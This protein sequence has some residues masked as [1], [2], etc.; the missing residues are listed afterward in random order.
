MKA[1]RNR[2]ATNRRKAAGGNRSGAP[3]RMRPGSFF[4]GPGGFYRRAT[5]SKKAKQMGPL[6]K[7]IKKQDPTAWEES[8]SG[9]P[10]SVWIDLRFNR[11][12]SLLY[13]LLRRFSSAHYLSEI[14]QI[15]QAVNDL[16][17]RLICFDLDYP[18]LMR[19]RAIQQ[20]KS[21]HPEIPILMLTEYHSEAV[22]VWALRTRVWDYLVKPLPA[23]EFSNRISNIIRLISNREESEKPINSMP[24]PPIPAEVRF[25]VARSK[26]KKTAP[27]LSCIET[28]YPEK[29]TLGRV[30]GLCGMGPF[31]FSRMFKRENGMTFQEFLIQYRI[32]KA[33]ELFRNPHISV[34]EVAFA[35]GFNDLSY[36][37]RV[38]R[39][40][41]GAVPSQFYSKVKKRI[42]N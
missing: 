21:R 19:F 10:E 29:I 14:K 40:Y 1:R 18:D 25:Y 4:K 42:E 20:T 36:F 35:V 30:A 23:G 16:K 33:L 37:S 7:K 22:A 6:A 34:T 26:G 41:V 8:A 28:D 31:Q 17:P 2:T 15:P 3:H 38:F 27:A 39:K 9:L 13:D 32:K 12:D 5:Q 11:F 24:A